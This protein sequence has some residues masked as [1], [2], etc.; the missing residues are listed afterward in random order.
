MGQGYFTLVLFHFCC[1]QIQRATF[2]LPQRLDAPR[3]YFHV[4]R[5]LPPFLKY[6]GTCK[7][8]IVPP[9]IGVG[10]MHS[11]NIFAE[12]IELLPNASPHRLT[13]TFISME[14]PK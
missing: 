2:V 14:V 10:V 13:G 1:A 8:I 6:L 12:F 7:Q 3:K 11:G 5:P 9:G 4:S